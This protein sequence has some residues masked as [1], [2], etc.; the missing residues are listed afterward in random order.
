[1]NDVSHGRSLLGKWLVNF[2]ITWNCITDAK[3]WGFGMRMG[4]VLIIVEKKEVFYEKKRK[5]CF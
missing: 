5:N 3:K 1:V 2:L 4:G